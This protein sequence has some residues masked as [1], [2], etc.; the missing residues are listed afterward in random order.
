MLVNTPADFWMD[1]SPQWHCGGLT[2]YPPPPVS[3]HI[4][5]FIAYSHLY[6]T[7]GDTFTHTV[8]TIYH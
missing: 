5:A 6:I 8:A 2:S 7:L 4:N 3:V 1:P